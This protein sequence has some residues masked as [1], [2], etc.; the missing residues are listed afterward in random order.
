MMKMEPIKESTKIGTAFASI[1]IIS[2]KQS[3]GLPIFFD[4][5]P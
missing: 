5:P 1:I 2:D 3:E 4:H